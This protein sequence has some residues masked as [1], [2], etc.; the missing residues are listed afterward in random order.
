MNEGQRSYLLLID[1]DIAALAKA[2]SEIP[3]KVQTSEFVVCRRY[4]P[5]GAERAIPTF[6]QRVIML[7]PVPDSRG[8]R[9]SATIVMARGGTV[10]A[11]IPKAI[12]DR[13]SEKSLAMAVERRVRPIATEPT[14]MN[15]FLFFDLS[16][17][18]PKKGTVTRVTYINT[19][20]SRLA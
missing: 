8:G 14:I 6:W 11:E 15:G 17:I 1:D 4:P 12:T 20:A 18:Q 2:K 3:R 16:E 13:M 5:K 9:F 7:N 19:L 10:P